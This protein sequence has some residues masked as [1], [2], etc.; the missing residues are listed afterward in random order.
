MKLKF[1]LTAKFLQLAEVVEGELPVED[2]DQEFSGKGTSLLPSQ[3]KS[4]RPAL[5]T[6]PISWPVGGR[7]FDMGAGRPEMVEGLKAFFADKQITYLPY[8]KFN[9]D[10]Y[11][12]N[13]LA[14]LKKEKADVA[15]ASNLLNVIPG[16][17]NRLVVL[18][19]MYN[20]LKPGGKVYITV[21]HTSGKEPGQSGADKWQNHMPPAK[22]LDEIKQIFPD[23]KVTSGMIVATK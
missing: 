23:A 7:V 2:T 20:A 18:K 13:T 16:V 21:H 1:K 19:Q 4:G 3:M 17:E 9:G 11:N 6:K 14:E 8:D 15:T 10:T 5:F 22:Y 12:G